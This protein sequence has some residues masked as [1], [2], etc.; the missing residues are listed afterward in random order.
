MAGGLYP[1]RPFSLN[2]K[3]I[4]F[5]AAVAGGYWYLPPR[6]WWVLAMLMWLPYV[7]MAWYDHFYDCKDKM[8]P[9]VVPFG[10]YI[11]LPFKPDGYKREYSK[12]AQSQ[13]DT[14]GRVDHVVA[15]TALVA[16]MAYGVYLYK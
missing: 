7:S 16:L 2:I 14:M 8:D 11:F 9:T 15:W 5:T 1:G 10:R 6:S 3:C 12:M 4:V 13:L